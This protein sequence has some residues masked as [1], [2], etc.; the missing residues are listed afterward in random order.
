MKKNIT[1]SDIAKKLNV[2][3]GLVSLVLR[4]KWKE[5]RISEEMAKKVNQAAKQLGYKPNAMAQAL[6]TGKSKIIG[7]IVA[8]IANPFYGKIARIIEN[9]AYSRGYQ[10]I[11]G[12]SDEDL[13]KFEHVIEAMKSRQVDGLLVVPVIGSQKAL[14]SI[15][16]SN[17]PTISIDRYLSDTDIPHIVTDNYNGSYAI[18]KYLKK[19]G[20]KNIAFITKDSQ[21]SNF[22]ERN[23]GFEKAM[24]DLQLNHHK[25][26]LSVNSWKQELP[27]LLKDIDTNSFD[28]IYLAQN[29]LAVEALKNINALNNPNL[30]QIAL[31]SFDDPEI[32]QINRPTIT[33]FQQPLQ[34]LAQ[35]A[36]Y[37]LVEAIEDKNQKN[38]STKIE[39][40][41]IPRQSC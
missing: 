28:A 39:G 3:V 32:F 18:G 41:L 35:K 23:N 20:Y 6:R 40:K 27:H 16:Q 14:Q 31:I 34:Q 11:F 19:K 10:V 29:M 38:V 21:L 26:L 13:N 2:S 8:D 7:L 33:C 9:E 30:N 15:F 5:N 36:V 25:F 4:E 17:I 37:S 24:D 12:S 1:L 22:I